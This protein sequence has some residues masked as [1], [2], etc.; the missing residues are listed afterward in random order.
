LEDA[1]SYVTSRV[2]F[3]EIDIR[4][5]ALTVN[6]D[7]PH[8]PKFHAEMTGEEVRRFGGDIERFER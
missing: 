1:R 7:A 5:A 3:P 2:G 4:T 6:R 8:P